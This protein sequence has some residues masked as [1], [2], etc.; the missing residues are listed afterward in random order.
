MI[1]SIRTKM[2][3]IVCLVFVIN[4]VGVIYI[5]I[6]ATKRIIVSE[7]E[8]AYANQLAVIIRTLETRHAKLVASGME[9][10]FAEGYKR[11]AAAELGALY[12]ADDPIIYPFI[13]DTTGHVVLHPRLE[14][15]SN[16]I[17]EEDF[18]RVMLAHKTGVQQYRWQGEDKWMVYRTFDPWQWTVAYAI[19]STE[20]FAAVKAVTRTTS[21]IMAVS[22]LLGIVM[23]AFTLSR[24]I[25]PIRVLAKDA[26]IIGEGQYSHAVT[27]VSGRNEISQLA[28][29]LSTMATNIQARDRKIR[30]FNVQLEQRV[31]E[32]TADL[33]ASEER[34]RDVALSSADWIWETDPDGL[35]TFS[36]GHILP[37]LGYDHD[38]I[39]GRSVYA[40]MPDEEVPRMR[41]LLSEC[42]RQK[43]AI[44]NYE[45]WHRTRSGDAI[46]L[47][48]NGVPI[49]DR[50]KGL[51]GFRGVHKDI[52]QRRRY[53]EALEAAKQAAEEATRAKS[54]FL[55]NMSHEI[56]TPMNGIMGMA[57]LLAGTP[58]N[59]E[60][61]DYTQTIQ[62]SADA[63]LHI[64]ND[65]LDFSKIEAGKLQF[66]LINFD[67]QSSM[68]DVSEI[69]AVK[70]YEKGLEFGAIVQSS[71]PLHL[72]GDPG[73]L[74]QVLMN[75]CSNA[76]KFTEQGQIVIRVTTES[77]TA[78]H[79]ELRFS[80]TDTGIGI[81]VERQKRLFKAFSQVDASTTRQYGG[82]GLG[83]V[84]CKQL[85]ELMH[86]TIHV[87]SVEGRGSTFWFTATFEK[88]GDRPNRDLLLPK[89]ISG[90]RV[91]VVDDISVN[92]EILTTYLKEWEC[93]TEAASSAPEAL[94]QI[95]K[96]AKADTP[97]DL[98][99]IDHMVPDMGGEE[100]GISIKANP[101]LGHTQLIM[102]TSWS[103]RGD[104][105]N[106]KTIGSDAYL[107]K[108]IKRDRLY[109][110]I[111]ALFGSDADAE[112]GL[113]DSDQVTRHSLEELDRINAR[114]LV[115]ED[116]TT[117]QKVAAH[118]LKKMGCRPHLVANGREA[119]AAFRELPLD[120]ILMDV[121]M[122]EMDGLRATEEIRR[123]E[124]SRFDG[125]KRGDGG[126]LPI[127]AMTANAMKGDREQCLAAGMDDYLAKPINP[128]ELGAKL[129]QWLDAG[130]DKSLA[131]VSARR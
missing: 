107:T 106:A 65:I 43:K 109:H 99:I 55:A 74:R 7:S 15:G 73:R 59:R 77:E 115:A 12:Y 75:L 90:K 54:E 123:I 9:G 25:G 108:P 110:A 46:C 21:A 88:Q 13:I 84:I 83:L 37:I 116:N 120:A 35:Y 5:N 126:R 62:S 45:F 41:A 87:E 130:G 10:L 131:H 58:L 81:P 11:S 94:L 119:V 101:E 85:V 125:A 121:Q 20:K 117:N 61:K 69:L 26:A 63:L 104:T 86:G 50:D 60:Q 72:K 19:K 38:E 31:A 98:A 91:L 82:T 8:R 79:A 40:L 118:I 76:I 29:S 92:R 80:V 129:V 27:A 89:D 128:E 53:E 42:A 124:S 44:V 39:I 57:G 49:F 3:L 28:A 34:F 23:I 24:I 127:I 47:A 36:S 71:V 32:R 48:T 70:A 6:A 100:L 18:T 114:I 30:K 122:P 16:R 66:E 112:V 96:A 102:L 14:P 67:L 56:R 78:T 97:F 1:K 64:I 52:T 95:H 113:Q 33:L 17:K 4:M 22:S 68:D 111:R 93:H 51:L 2:L 105:Q 103:Q